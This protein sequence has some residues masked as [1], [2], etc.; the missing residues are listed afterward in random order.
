MKMNAK[1]LIEFTKRAKSMIIPWKRNYPQTDYEKGWND[2]I[3]EARNNYNKYLK[4]WL[5]MVEE[6]EN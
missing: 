5:K 1:E 4:P 6:N 2:A 3:K